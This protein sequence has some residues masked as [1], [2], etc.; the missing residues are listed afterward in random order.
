MRRMMDRSRGD[1]GAALLEF[2]LIV[3]VL[4]LLIFGIMK[5]ALLLRDDVAMTH[6]V[7][8]ASR[9]A[10]TN[11]RVG[12]IEGHAGPPGTL[13]S[14]GTV[15]GTAVPSFAYFASQV[16]ERSGSGLP[17]DSI[18]DMWVFLPNKEGYPTTTAD[19]KN[20]QNR[21]MTCL[22]AFCVRYTWKDAIDGFRWDGVSTWDPQSV[23]ACPRAASVDPR[24]PDGQAVG[25]FLRVDHVGLFNGFFNTSRTLTD[26]SVVKFEPMRAVNC[27]PAP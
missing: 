2:A 22:P 10:S 11:P 4:L 20:N 14:G 25:I 15:P 9:A 1:S 17:K 6:L 19:W 13:P 21:T 18:K 5:F 12:N 24:N 7:R 27:K 16:V 26:R 3:P 23:N 8:D